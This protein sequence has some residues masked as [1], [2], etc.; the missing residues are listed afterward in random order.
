MRARAAARTTALR[1]LKGMAD[2]L[3][4]EIK[5]GEDLLPVLSTKGYPAAMCEFY[6]N[7]FTEPKR[8]LETSLETW[9]NKAKTTVDSSE[10]ADNDIADLETVTTTLETIWKTT[11]VE[12]SK[13]LKN[14]T[15]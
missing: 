14:L 8:I 6:T 1:K 11:K 4:K 15:A 12:V 13:D 3:R 7:K 10:G 2:K 5:D 9:S